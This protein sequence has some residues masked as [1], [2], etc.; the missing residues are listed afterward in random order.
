MNAYKCDKCG[1]YYEGNKKFSVN[2]DYIVG[3]STISRCRRGACENFDLCD[4]CLKA[5][6][7]FMDVKNK[8]A[9]ENDG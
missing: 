8:K 9:N 3:I 7:D 4:D 5:F 1:K 2:G 6:Y